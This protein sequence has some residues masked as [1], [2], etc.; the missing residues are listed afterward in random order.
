MFERGILK[1]VRR[2]KGLKADDTAVA[3]GLL[4]YI[5]LQALWTSRQGCFDV[6]QKTIPTV[7]FVLLR[8]RV[9][10]DRFLC[11]IRHTE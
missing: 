10:M 2:S 7:F 11:K 3:V 4:T 9:L 1:W 8:G 5:S 6:V